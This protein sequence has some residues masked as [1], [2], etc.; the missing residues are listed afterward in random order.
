MTL[1]E[2]GSRKVSEQVLGVTMAHALRGVA[3][4]T[5]LLGTSQSKPCVHS[6][7]RSL[8]SATMAVR[9]SLTLVILLSATCKPVRTSGSPYCYLLGAQK[10]KI[11]QGT[12]TSVRSECLGRHSLTTADPGPEHTEF[13]ECSQ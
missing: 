2:L 8:A 1:E 7:N 12:S 11:P 13:W 4:L 3:S 5:S 6:Y 10:L 9:R